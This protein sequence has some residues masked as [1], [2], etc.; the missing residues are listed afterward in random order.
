MAEPSAE[1]LPGCSE[2]VP[3]IMRQ[4]ETVK[5]IAIEHIVELLG[6]IAIK[7][8]GIVFVVETHAA[9]IEIG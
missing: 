3:T 5:F 9:G 7:Y 4:I 1:F 8:D 2:F 6:N